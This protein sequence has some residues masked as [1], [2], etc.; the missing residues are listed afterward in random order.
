MANH[1]DDL[2]DTKTS[3]Q[4]T[5][6]DPFQ[7]LAA[8]VT[9]QL[10]GTACAVL[11]MF[12]RASLQIVGASGLPAS[13]VRAYHRSSQSLD[14]LT[15]QVLQ[16]QQ[17]A[18]Q[19]IGPDHP[20]RD[21]NIDALAVLPLP[22]S[23]LPGYPQLLWVARSAH[24]RNTTGTT[25][26]EAWL[27]TVLSTRLTTP[28]TSPSPRPPSV[29]ILNL[30]HPAPAPAHPTLDLS[31]L[32][33]EIHSPSTPDSLTAPARWVAIGTD[34]GI[35]RPA[36]IRRLQVGHAKLAVVAFQ[37]KAADWHRLARQP[38]PCDPEVQRM[39]DAVSFIAE[40]FLRSPSLQ[41]VSKHVHVSPYHFHRRFTELLGITPKHLLLEFQVHI[42]KNLLATGTE[43]LR[44]VASLAGFAHQSHFT[45]RFKQAT[46]LTPLK[47]QRLTATR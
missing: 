12:P 24:P 27:A 43:S 11:A 1:S 38:I 25:T 42:A 39:L 35:L 47:W 41:E 16:T 33:Q 13:T 15:W 34:T 7:E 8:S 46:G 2:V 14:T 9:R 18:A 36:R 40:H 30:D 21:L 31:A 22:H 17:P 5:T 20:L 32:L 44:Q 29:L 10:P 3:F 37:P 4:D 23:L 45:S 28:T 19:I 26:A 6:Q